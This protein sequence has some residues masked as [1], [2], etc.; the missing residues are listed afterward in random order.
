MKDFYSE[1]FD[2]LSPTEST[3]L[4]VKRSLD[5]TEMAFYLNSLKMKLALTLQ[6]IEEIL[7]AAI[8]GHL[9]SSLFFHHKLLD[10]ATSRGF[11]E[12]P[13]SSF[14]PI[15]LVLHFF[16]SNCSLEMFYAVPCAASPFTVAKIIPLPSI[17]HQV[18]PKISH[19]LIAHDSKN[20]FSSI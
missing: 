19:S 7:N 16:K 3:I 14:R 5:S 15:R 6:E 10:F 1:V 20:L 13:S 18:V 2:A 4:A 9:H 11:V 8:Q 17:R 12:K